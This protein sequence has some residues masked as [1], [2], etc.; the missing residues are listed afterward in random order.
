MLGLSV[1]LTHNATNSLDFAEDLS[2]GTGHKI[3]VGISENTLGFHTIMALPTDGHLI[4]VNY[5]SNPHMMFPQ[6]GTATGIYGLAGKN[7][8]KISLISFLDVITVKNNV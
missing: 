2:I 8:L 6:T 3:D 4:P 5:Y 1:G 7:N